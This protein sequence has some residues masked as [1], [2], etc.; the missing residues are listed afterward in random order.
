M[1]TIHV[2]LSTQA[3]QSSEDNASKRVYKEILKISKSYDIAHFTA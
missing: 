3:S 2:E 1:M